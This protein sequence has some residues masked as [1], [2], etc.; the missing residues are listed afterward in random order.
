M[1]K[2]KNKRIVTPVGISQYAWLT[3]PDT[4]FDEEGVFKVNLMLVTTDAKTLIQ[5]IDDS[6]KDSITLAKEKAK[7]KNIKEAPLP[8]SAELDDKNNLTGNTIFKFK[9]KAQITTS[10]GTVIPNRVA[11]FDSKG[12][13]LVD[14]NI[15]SG[16]E[17]KISADVIPYY[18]S[19]VGAGVSLRLRACQITKLV[20]GGGYSA[21]GYGFAEETGYEVTTEESS[22]TEEGKDENVLEESKDKETDF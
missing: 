5:Q 21:T 10:N 9:C 13:P 18:T 4:R 14:V 8:Y 1:P 19:M 3:S 20:E 11:L 16:S 17:M 22:D 12:T 7:G 6:L 2:K 15:W